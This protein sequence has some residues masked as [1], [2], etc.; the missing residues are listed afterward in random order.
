[1]KLKETVEL[2]CKVLDV[3]RHIIRRDVEKGLLPNFS[4]GL[5][6]FEHLYNTIG[7]IGVYETMKRFGYVRVDEFGNTYY[8]DNADVFGKKIFDVIHRRKDLRP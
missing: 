3:V 8:T 1:M 5:V 2:D 7:V 6:D 4:Y